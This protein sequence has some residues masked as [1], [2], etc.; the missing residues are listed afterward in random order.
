MDIDCTPLRGYI[1]VR[2]TCNSWFFWCLIPPDDKLPHFV[3]MVFDDSIDIYMRAKC[4]T[5]KAY[6][7]TLGMFLEFAVKHSGRH[8]YIEDSE[9]LIT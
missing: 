9:E 4:D 5:R 3:F 1:S 7:T 8:D 2:R 6:L